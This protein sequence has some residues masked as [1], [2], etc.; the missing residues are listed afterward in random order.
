M[1]KLY[2]W[3]L[4]ILALLGAFGGV[5]LAADAVDPSDGSLDVAKAIYNAFSGGH[6]A[7]AAAMGLILGVA[8]VKRYLGPKIPWLHSDVGGTSLTL[9]GAFATAMA[10][11]L[12]A[13]TAAISMGLLKSSLLVGIGA[14]GGYTVLKKLVIEPLI[15]P[16]QKMLPPWAQP[17]FSIVLWVFDKP[18]A[19]AQV[20]ANAAAAG[21]AAV[22]ANPGQGVATLP[23]TTAVSGADSI[24]KPTELK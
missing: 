18:D 8:L 23:T 17:I 19:A 5:A 22:A 20:E 24:G 10:A 11:G 7:Y 12:A 6:Y 3:M 13:P 2:V 14:A 15:K 21:S 9:A 1:K 16:L 4:G